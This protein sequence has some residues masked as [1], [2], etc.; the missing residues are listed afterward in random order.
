MAVEQVNFNSSKLSLNTPG[1]SKTS[2]ADAQ[3]ATL[4]QNSIFKLAAAKSAA[5]NSKSTA[6][7]PEADK[8]SQSKG[9]S[10]GKLFTASADGKKNS[11]EANQGKDKT[12]SDGTIADRDKTTLTA[13]KA[14]GTQETNKFKA[15]ADKSGKQMKTIQAEAQKATAEGQSAQEELASLN[16][17]G[18]KPESQKAAAGS[19]APAPAPAQ[20]NPFAGLSANNQD[21]GGSQA[22][23]TQKSNPFAGLGTQ[24][25]QATGSQTAGDESQDPNQSKKDAL[26]SKIESSSKTLTGLS[27]QVKLTQ[28]TTDTSRAQLMKNL[29]GLSKFSQ[30]ADESNKQRKSFG[31]KVIKIGE[32]TKGVG[33]Q[34]TSISTAG[35]L[36]AAA[37]KGTGWG[38]GASLVIDK[39]STVGDQVGKYTSLAGSATKMA[40]QVGEGK[41]MAALGTGL[42][43]GASYAASTLAAN[44][45]NVSTKAMYTLGNMAVQKGLSLIKPLKA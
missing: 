7:N 21:D 8:V 28:K 36:V 22:A 35:H 19:A 16:S 40:A 11:G 23:S 1:G 31:D 4:K 37:L 12:T 10:L 38:T 43:A 27:K 13:G 41:F 25:Q 34:V 15:L 24:N 32:T 44:T 6:E 29:S 17:T 45:K 42:S 9:F 39:A 20:S 3:K 30:Q 5:N 33:D 18:D 26:N 2:F 14:K